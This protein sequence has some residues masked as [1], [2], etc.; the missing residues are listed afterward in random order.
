MFSVPISSFAKD[1]LTIV[2]NPCQK[3]YRYMVLNFWVHFWGALNYLVWRLLVLLFP[4]FSLEVAGSSVHWF[5]CSV[6]RLL[7]PLFLFGDYWFLCSVWRLLIPLFS[8]E[9][10]DS[11]V[12][13]GGCWFLC[14]HLVTTGSSVGLE[15]AGSSVHWFL[16][17]VWR[18]L[19]TLF[20]FGDY[21]F[22]C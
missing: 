18:L 13:S 3:L 9:V 4:L 7:V 10:A 22:L 2:K 8:L 16:C 12:Q 14:S 11:S 6:R 17:S 19:V 5:L 1:L 21:W 20:L 15:V